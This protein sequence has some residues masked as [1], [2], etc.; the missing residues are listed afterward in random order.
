[1]ITKEQEIPQS[2]LKRILEWAGF[3]QSTPEENLC[4]ERWA[5]MPHGE[6][7][8]WDSLC[9]RLY[10]LDFQAKWLWPKLTH[11]KIFYYSDVEIVGLLTQ[12]IVRNKRMD[13]GKAEASDPAEAVLLA[14]LDMLKGEK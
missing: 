1:M 13:G 4:Y 9:E 5:K 14:V 6:F 2:D 12:V 7:Q 10:S 8:P 11:L 3:K